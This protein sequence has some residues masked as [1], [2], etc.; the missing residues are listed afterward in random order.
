MPKRIPLTDDIKRMITA[1]VGSEPNW[2]QV[3]VFET[4]AVTGR[5]I[6]QRYSIY[7]G[8]VVQVDAMEAMA[9]HVNGGGFVPLH[10]LHEQRWSL[11]SGRVFQGKVG[12]DE[13]NVPQLHNLF[14]IDTSDEAGQSLAA[15]VDN[16]TI[17]EVSVGFMAEKLLCSACNFDYMQ[18][19]DAVWDRT[20][21]NGHVLGMGGHHLKLSGLKS[22]LELSLVS[23]GASTGAKILPE[24]KR[25][26][27]S[28]FESLAA[29]C[30]NPERLVL[31]ASPTLADEVD[32]KEIEQLQASLDALTQT[33]SG[34]K[35]QV[36][37][38]ATKL[39][40]AEAATADL[41]TKLASAEETIV[42]QKATIEEQATQLAAV[43]ELTTKVGELETKLSA[44]PAPA[45]KQPGPFKLPLGGI[46]NLKATADKSGDSNRPN[47]NSAFK[48]KQK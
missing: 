4:A 47:R 46:E 40:A 25:L 11:P 33:V 27:A 32:M 48:T 22:Y 30:H 1:S 15:K 13:E 14:F 10:L 26:L 7:D 39:A 3:A 24:K 23:K 42:A 29:S 8:A 17:E 37:E 19:E 31:F 21:A 18:D 20:C 6:N 16:G 41:G 28:Q 43:G 2:E 38:Q 45:P 5:P 9:Q 35:D 44:E 36:T 34:L 12:Y